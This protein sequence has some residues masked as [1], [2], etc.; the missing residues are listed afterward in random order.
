M[1]PAWLNQAR[2]SFQRATLGIK[3]AIDNTDLT[4][5]EA[6]R[7]LNDRIMRVRGTL[8]LLVLLWNKGSQSNDLP[9]LMTEPSVSERNLGPTIDRCGTPPLYYNCILSLLDLRHFFFFILGWVHPPLSLRVP[10]RDALPSPPVRPRPPHSGVHRRVHWHGGSPCP[11]CPGY[12]EPAGL[13]QRHDGKHLGYQLVK[14]REVD[15]CSFLCV[16]LL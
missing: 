10:Y 5:Q 8:G 9:F 11:A 14:L 16:S 1:S 6:C 4:D 15:V 3:L 13:C 2:G 12:L 7:I